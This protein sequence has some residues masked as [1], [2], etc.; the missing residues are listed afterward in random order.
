MPQA[1]CSKCSFQLELPP[2]VPFANVPCPRCKGALSAAPDRAANPS[3]I[4]PRAAAA[5]K[6]QR[7]TAT[8]RDNTTSRDHS[9]SART[10]TRTDRPSERWD[11]R[12]AA[13]AEVED[14]AGMSLGLKL[15]LIALPIVA[16]IAAVVFIVV[17]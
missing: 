16:L 17:N 13:A 6:P 8:P 5:A 3:P 9:P 7:A 14:E 12:P 15:T 4:P 10:R 11:S 2:Q 1:L